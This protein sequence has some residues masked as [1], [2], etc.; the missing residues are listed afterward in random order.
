VSTRKK[1]LALVSKYM[2]NNITTLRYLKMIAISDVSAELLFKAIDSFIL[3]KG[4]PANKLYYF[5]NDE[6][7]NMTGLYFCI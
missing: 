1:T 7:S 5:G 4:L 3:Q 2:V 6:V